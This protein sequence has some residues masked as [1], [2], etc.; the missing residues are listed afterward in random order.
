MRVCACVCACMCV[1]EY[2]CVCVYARVRKCVRVY[3]CVCVRQGGS[4]TEVQIQELCSALN[5]ISIQHQSMSD[6]DSVWWCCTN[7]S[8]IMVNNANWD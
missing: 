8:G 3:V 1:C 6:S 4:W 2:V 5:N 7:H